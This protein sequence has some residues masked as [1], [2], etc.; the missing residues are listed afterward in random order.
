MNPKLYRIRLK[1]RDVYW[2]D[3]VE[4]GKLYKV[5]K[6]NDDISGTF[7]DKNGIV[8]FFISGNEWIWE[9]V[10]VGYPKTHFSDYTKQEKLITKE[11]K[12]S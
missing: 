11:L 4:V 1:S 3:M 7:I 10:K 5:S 2:E 12:C 6:F 9:L 8:H